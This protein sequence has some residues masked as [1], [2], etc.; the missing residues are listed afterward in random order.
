[1]SASGGLRVA[2]RQERAVLAHPDQRTHWAILLFA[3]LDEPVGR[4]R[5]Q[6]RIDDLWRRNP[7]VGARL[8]GELWLRGDAPVVRDCGPAHE[9]KGLVWGARFALDREP[10]L[11]VHL[12]GSGRTLVVEGHHAAFDGLA[13]VE[14][15]KALTSSVPTGAGA[16]DLE[17]DAFTARRDHV[18]SG[19]DVRTG[20]SRTGNSL[21]RRALL[22][23]SR[24]A[25]SRPRPECEALVSE[26]ITVARG[27]A[28]TARYAQACADAVVAHNDRHGVR[29]RRIGI[30]LGLGGAHVIGNTASYRRVD[31]DIRNG[32][33]VTAAVLGAIA[34]PAEPSELRF[35]PRGAGVVMRP[36]TDRFS[37]SFLISNLGVLDLP[38][39]R[40]ISFFPV[41][42]GRSAVAFGAASSAPGRAT[43]SL[44][45]RD[46]AVDDATLLLH[47][48]AARFARADRTVEVHP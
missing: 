44:R 19:S 23:A 31:I 42:R 48:V 47:D 7:I 9:A 38:G 34:D 26:D 22:P 45:A 33:D 16:I 32:V 36:V 30:S 28:F 5:L 46:L 40:R 13:L 2:T 29:V 21:V 4:E 12:I 24:V 8:Q 18:P 39:I 27:G 14:V 11:R 43:L 35:A 3:D 6:E 15:V 17:R 37:D 25:P 10:P 41:A 1:M 20:N